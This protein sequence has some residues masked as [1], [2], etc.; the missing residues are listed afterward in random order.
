[1][2][3]INELDNRV[4]KLEEEMGK[5]TYP[6]DIVSQKAIENAFFQTIKALKFKGGLPIYTAIRK[7][8]PTEGE[9][10][11]QTIGSVNSFCACISGTSYCVTLPIS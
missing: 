1:M 11:L 6:M 4:K 2:P 5:I 10:Y 8:K 9:I 3:D 7:D